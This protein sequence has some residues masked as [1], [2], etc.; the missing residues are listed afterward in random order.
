MERS[1]IKEILAALN[2][3]NNQ[4]HSEGEIEQQMEQR[5]KGTFDTKPDFKRWMRSRGLD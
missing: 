1:E 2:E 3:K 5:L 4:H